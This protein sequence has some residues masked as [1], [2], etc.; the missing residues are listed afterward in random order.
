MF[1]V[2]DLIGHTGFPKWRGLVSVPGES[3]V[4]C[5]DGITSIDGEPSTYFKMKS[6]RGVGWY[7]IEKEKPKNDI[8]DFLF[9][10]RDE[11]I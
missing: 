10:E 6:Y 1:E 5:Y 3:G 4:F 7:V 9:V 2:G 8:P 11:D